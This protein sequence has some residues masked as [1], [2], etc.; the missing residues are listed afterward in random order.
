MRFSEDDGKKDNNW[1][2][3]RLCFTLNYYQ[4]TPELR[5][6]FTIDLKGEK[7]GTKTTKK[8]KKRK[9]EI[10]VINGPAES[11]G[12][13]ALRKLKICTHSSYPPSKP[14]AKK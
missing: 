2:L 12:F 4:A 10:K 11:Q 1:K 14:R 6:I 8:K 7:K 5:A 13:A 3:I 9:E